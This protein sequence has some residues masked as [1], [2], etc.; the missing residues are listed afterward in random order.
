MQTTRKSLE[1]MA[2]LNVCACWHFDLARTIDEVDDDTLE[3]IIHEPYILH[4]FQQAQDPVSTKE[5]MKS[6]KECPDYRMRGKV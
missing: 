1:T 6:L 3:A 2:Q 5:F 4:Y